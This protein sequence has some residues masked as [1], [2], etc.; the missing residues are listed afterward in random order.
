MNSSCRI[1]IAKTIAAIRKE[2]KDFES[3]RDAEQEAFDNL[4][5]SLQESEKGEKMQ[6]NID[7]LESALDSINEALDDL[8]QTIE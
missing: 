7:A 5:E 4:P 8:E 1:L 2:L 6:E 3:V